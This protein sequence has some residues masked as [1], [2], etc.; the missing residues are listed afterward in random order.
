MGYKNK[1]LT[2]KQYTILYLKMLD[3]SCK[4]NKREWDKLLAMNSVTLVCYC[5]KNT[6]CHRHLLAKY[7]ADKFSNQVE[8][9]G[10]V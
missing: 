1:S 10:E 4:N 9:I 6:F 7:L 2:E 8:L 3:A 5:P